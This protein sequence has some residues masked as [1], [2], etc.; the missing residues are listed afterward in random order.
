[1]GFETEGE[2]CG[3]KG[4]EMREF[5]GVVGDGSMPMLLGMLLGGTA[6]M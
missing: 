6:G 2:G 3:G 5:K 1:V 4:A